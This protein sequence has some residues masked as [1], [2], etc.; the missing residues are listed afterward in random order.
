MKE[1]ESLKEKC[2]YYRSKYDTALEDPQ[3]HTLVMLD[4]RSFSKLIKKKYKLPFDEKFIDLMNQTAS[5]LAKN[6]QGTRI[7]YVQ[8]DEIT[9][10]LRPKTE[11]SDVFFKGRIE[12]LLSIIP[13]MASGFFNMKAHLGETEEYEPIQFD[14]KVWQVPDLN[15]VIA[16]FLYRQNDCVR[17]SKNQAAQTYISHNQLR[18][19]TADE[20]IKL[21]EEEKGIKW[22]DYS[23][24][25]KYGRFIT[26]KSELYK[27]EEMNIEYT[28]TFW[29]PIDGFR[30]DTPSRREELKKIIEDN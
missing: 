24:G 2:L 20:A 29:D 25:E 4:G 11:V 16:W 7:G 19:K 1:F 10:Y 15:D 30:L 12:K 3:G 13:S 18:R 22:D 5:Y 28:R 9:L 21:L 6:V 23:P 8:S 17:N 27:N 14:C 26:K